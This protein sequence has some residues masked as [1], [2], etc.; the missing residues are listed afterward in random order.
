[1]SCDVLG[2]EA[3]AK[4]ARCYVAGDDIAAT[5]V[6]KGSVFATGGFWGSYASVQSE[7]EEEKVGLWAGEADRPQDYR[8]KRWEEA[9]KAAP[10]G[11]PIKGPIRSGGR[12][13]VLPWAPSYDS[14]RLRASRGE[15]WFCSESEAEAAGWT[16][17][18]QS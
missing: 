15:R 18:S 10:D 1:V 17:G 2:E 6:R 7:A 8:D 3:N 9:K 16:R 5:L 13:Y 12:V 14:I 11:C 4:R